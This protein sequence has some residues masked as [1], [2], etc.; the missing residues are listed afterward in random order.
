MQF[1]LLV[2]NDPALVEAL[3]D[4]QYDSMMKDCIAHADQLREQGR[5]IESR[6]LGHPAAAKS[7]RIRQGKVSAL[8]GPFACFPVEWSYSPLVSNRAARNCEPLVV[9]LYG[10]LTA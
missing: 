7:V 10:P 4:G 1:M 8:D 2:Y 3:P 6:M 9:T 5:L